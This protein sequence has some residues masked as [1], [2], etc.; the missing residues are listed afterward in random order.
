MTKQDLARELAKKA[1]IT[2]YQAAIDIDALMGIMQEAFI[3]GKSIYLR[4]FGTFKVTTRKAKVGQNINAGTSVVIPER[5]VVLF[6]AAPVLKDAM[7]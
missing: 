5:Q 7:N 1:G 2:T 3:E 4:G 6:K